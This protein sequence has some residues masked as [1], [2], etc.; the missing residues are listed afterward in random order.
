MDSYTP[1]VPEFKLGLYVSEIIQ[2]QTA[3]KGET[4]D[5]DDTLAARPH[6]E[7]LFGANGV[8]ANYT[9]PVMNVAAVVSALSYAEKD[10]NLAA[11]AAAGHEKEE[12]Y[13]AQLYPRNVLITNTLYANY[14]ISKI[15][16]A[17]ITE[18]TDLVKEM[19]L[20]I[21]DDAAEVAT[22]ASAIKAHEFMLVYSPNITN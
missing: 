8:Y 17:N 5:A 16:F 11:Q 15:D 10:L 21:A 4:Y 12:D 7:D 14:S 2:N 22:K 6:T 19:Y 3:W 18:L 13:D 9:A 1:F 20:T